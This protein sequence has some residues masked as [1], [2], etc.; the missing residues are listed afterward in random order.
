MI[1]TP[2]TAWIKKDTLVYR[3][4]KNGSR[5]HIMGNETLGVGLYVTPN[6]DIA[7]IYGEPE[8]YRIA[9][10]LSLLIKDCH[11]WSKLIGK[12]DVM[13]QWGTIHE[14]SWILTTAISGAGFDGVYTGYNDIE[15]W[16]IFDS[17]IIVKVG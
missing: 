8:T 13:G 9:H 2:T 6:R 17:D 4:T 5:A 11:L 15:G 16:V 12:V 3:S 1:R 14:R 10:P 7:E